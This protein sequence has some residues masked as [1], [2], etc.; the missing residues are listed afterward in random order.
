MV[1]KWLTSEKRRGIEKV[2]LCFFI[3]KFLF[4]SKFLNLDCI[5]KAKIHLLCYKTL[6][7]IAFSILFQSNYYAL[8]FVINLSLN[9]SGVLFPVSSI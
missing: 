9:K 8:Q 1:V 3:K 2:P 5:F 7:F 6:V 4:G